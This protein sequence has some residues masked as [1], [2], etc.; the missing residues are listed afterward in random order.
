MGLIPAK[1]NSTAETPSPP[2]KAQKNKAQE[3]MR[4]GDQ[5]LYDL[6]FFLILFGVLGVSA[7]KFLDARNSGGERSQNGS[8]GLWWAV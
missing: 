2:R 7:M 1:A 6:S 3:T 4:S 8:C 5:D